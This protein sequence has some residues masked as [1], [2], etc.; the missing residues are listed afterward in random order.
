MSN[1]ETR[2]KTQVGWWSGPAGSVHSAP[3]DLSGGLARVGRP[4]YLLEHGDG[5]AF[6]HEGRAELGVDQ[7]DDSVPLLAV[8]PACRPRHLGSAS[9][10]RDH[11][12]RFCYV[13]GAMANGIASA[14]M[15][16]AMGRAGM[17]AFFGAAG[18]GPEAVEDAIDRISTRLGNLPWGFNL[19]HSPYEPRL[20]EAVADLYV[21]RGVNRVSASA[22]MDLTLPLVRYRLHGI[23]ADASGRV[24][25]PNRIVAKV[26][27]V[28]VARKFLAPAPTKMVAELV[29]RG[30]LT[31]K[32]ARLAESIPVAQD[33]TVE[34][35]S[36]GHTDN[37]P[38]IALLPTMLALRDRLHAE[39]GYDV[40]LRV[41]SAGGISTPHSV[42][43][44][45]AMGADY[46]MTG[47]VNQACR[48]A[49]TSDPVRRML[50]QAE[51]ADVTMAPAA[52]MF[53][54]GVKLQVLKRGT[55]FPMRAL[56]LY[57]LYLAHAGLE[58]IPADERKNLESTIFRTSLDDVWTETRRFWEQ[59]DPA[60][61]ERAG[62]DPKHRMALVF[63]WYLG[64]SSRWANRGEPG[65]E[66]DYQ[67]W[68][69]PAMGAFNEWARGSCL[70]SWEG[71]RVVS[72]AL[73]ML[74]GAAVMIRANALRSQGVE[75][76]A[77]SVDTR[78][79]ES[80][81]LEEL[82]S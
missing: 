51:Q 74:H 2:S 1:P 63:R 81:K 79:R 77:D 25:A 13:A 16:E 80:D 34:A 44:A 29:S 65:R 11:G 33:L 69:G 35:D 14:E 60:Q 27:R 61:V 8:A 67:V 47:S 30:D 52:D 4:L 26:S 22:Y 3:G 37:R 43:A 38:A 19:I 45:F 70:E 5:L 66:I 50:A 28:E 36:G 62:R 59:R 24:M 31:D 12:V 57:D 6:S 64:M 56:R 58:D 53:E 41:G 42:A 20:E 48:E 73:N 32:Q 46:V 72:V 15:V 54:M 71:R 76:P 49:G 55:M 9:F 68:C 10:A 75:L 78:P 23:H 18:L 82:L 7:A 21:R 40:P 17:L 39:H